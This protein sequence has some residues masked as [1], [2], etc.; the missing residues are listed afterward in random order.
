MAQSK[1]ALRSRIRSVK[2]TRK[3]TK[4][5]EMI[6]NAKLFK[7]RNR[8]EQN[9]EYAQRLQSTVASIAADSPDLDE[10]YL[11]PK[12]ST[13]AMTIVF[14]SDLGLCGAYNANV[15]KF[16]LANLNPAD[17]I[18]LI[19]TSMYHQFQEN[20]FHILNEKPISSDKL[21][22]MELKGWVEQ[23]THLYEQNEAGTVQV[24]YTRFIN[25]DRCAFANGYDEAEGGRR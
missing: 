4:A 19:G 24:L 16:A 23:G 11:K 9:R 25:T 10:M 20:G 18:V 14:T 7:Q 1:Q 12:T 15:L 8:M 5:M 2:S 17:P 22:L 3:I 21:T 6:A 13:M